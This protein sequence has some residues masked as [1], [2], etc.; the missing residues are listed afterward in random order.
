[1]DLINYISNVEITSEIDVIKSTMNGRYIDVCLL[2]LNQRL[3]NNFNLCKKT[4]LD[5]SIGK[6]AV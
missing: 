2:M 1:M 3:Y 5:S 6:A 4:W